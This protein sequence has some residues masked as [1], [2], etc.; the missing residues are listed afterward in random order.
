MRLIGHLTRQGYLLARYRSLNVTCHLSHMGQTHVLLTRN[1]DIFTSW[2][3]LVS[4][5]SFSGANKM[6]E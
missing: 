2:I 4:G 5:R 3:A 1:M 6:V